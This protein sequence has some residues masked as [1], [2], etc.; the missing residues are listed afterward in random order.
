[1]KK[2]K[3]KFLNTKGI[4][5]NQR[6]YKGIAIFGAP[7]SGKT[8]MAKLLQETFPKAKH[9]EASDRVINQAA[10]V[11]DHLPK[12]EV[13]FIKKITEIRILLQK[14]FQENRL[15]IYSLILKIVIHPLS[16]QKR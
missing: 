7:G 5:D 14:L 8:T 1:M 10:S 4:L 12:E 2:P 15:G 9:I 6:L 3:D 11:K 13:D 16:L